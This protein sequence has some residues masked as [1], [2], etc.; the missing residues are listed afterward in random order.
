MDILSRSSYHSK[1]RTIE[2]SKVYTVDGHLGDGGFSVVYRVHDDDDREY[3]IKKIEPD[4]YRSHGVPCLMEA[5]IMA[6][7]RHPNLNHAVSIEISNNCLYFVQEVAIATLYR[8]V[9]K[10]NTITDDMVLYIIN[11]I[12]QGLDFLHRAG[13][14]HGD[15]KAT[16]VLVFKDQGKQQDVTFKLAD[17]NLTSFRDWHSA[18][19]VCTSSYR[20]LEVWRKDSD[21]DEKIDIWGLGCVG[22]YTKYRDPLFESQGPKGGSDAEFKYLNALFDWE[23]EWFTKIPPPRNNRGKKHL[24][25]QH[26]D[27]SYLSP[28]IDAAIFGTDELNILL[29][30]MLCP[31][32]DGRPRDTDEILEYRLMKRKHGK[33]EAGEFKRLTPLQ[34]KIIPKL[35]Q[36][37]KGIIVVDNLSITRAHRDMFLGTY[38]KLDSIAKLSVRIYDR[39]LQNQQNYRHEDSTHAIKT[40][41]V[42]IAG[43]MVRADERCEDPPNVDPAVKLRDIAAYRERHL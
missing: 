32:P 19:P 10:E 41:V 24:K 23:D 16:N 5:S 26:Y 6:S 30:N 8:W 9:S 39:F 35:I 17:F 18:I 2:L 31:Y 14:I 22:Y 28:N 3:A 12:C 33:R 4:S 43:K 15:V 11:Q 37:P 36:K 40:A 21:W 42:W 29:S 13:I 1:K 27:V 34:A 20:P 7:Y 25:R 38:T